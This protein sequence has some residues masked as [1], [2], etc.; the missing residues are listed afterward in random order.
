M[1][2]LRQRTERNSFVE[3][4]LKLHVS[5]GDGIANDNEIGTRCEISGRKWLRDWNAEGCQKIGHGRVRRRIRSRDAKAAL[6][7]HSGQR[8]HRSTADAD[9]VNV[10]LVCHEVENPLAECR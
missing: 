6:V 8:G 5:A 2:D 1:Q 7:E 3:Y 10:L 4:V 9:Q